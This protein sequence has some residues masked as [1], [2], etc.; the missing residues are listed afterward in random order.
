MIPIPY[1][2]LDV[3]ASGSTTDA[4]K[5]DGGLVLP[6]RERRRS[7]LVGRLMGGEKKQKKD[8]KA[9]KSKEGFRLVRMT[10]GEYLMYWAKDEEG[11]YIGTEPVENRA[12]FWK[13]REST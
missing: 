11:R 12:E 7:S 4:N 9:K 8:K 3:S 2:D 5:D 1:S 13:L 6:E 10:R